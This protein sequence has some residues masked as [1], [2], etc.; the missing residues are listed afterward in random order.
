MTPDFR[1]GDSWREAYRCDNTK[2]R[3]FSLTSPMQA[4]R[5]ATEYHDMNTI[6]ETEYPVVVRTCFAH[7]SAWERI[8]IAIRTQDDGSEVFVEFLDD[9]AYTG[10]TKEQLLSLLPADYRH[11]VLFVVDG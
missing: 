7:Q 4:T 9:P 2:R 11:P 8:R 5:P 10:A 3:G 1:R 6:P